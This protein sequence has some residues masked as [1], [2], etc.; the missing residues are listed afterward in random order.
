MSNNIFPKFNELFDQIFDLMKLR[1]S[2][3]K[4]MMRSYDELVISEMTNLILAFSD[5][6]LLENQLA[7]D[8]TQITQSM[9][10][11]FD[12]FNK[13]MSSEEKT[14]IYLYSKLIIFIEILQPIIENSKQEDVKKIGAILAQDRKFLEV[15]SLLGELNKQFL[16]PMA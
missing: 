13:N 10:D 5:S 9:T 3:K 4:A 2:E 15:F 8:Q 14:Q 1:G 6:P 7:T 11:L 12:K 16:A